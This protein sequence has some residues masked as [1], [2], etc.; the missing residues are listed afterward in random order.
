MCMT[1][2]IELLGTPNGTI[3]SQALNGKVQR[4]FRK[5]VGS[6]RSRSGRPRFT[7]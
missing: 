6:K 2:P 3:S 4:L 5:E 7:G 1:K